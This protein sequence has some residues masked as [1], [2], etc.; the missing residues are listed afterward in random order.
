LLKSIGE[1]CRRQCTVVHFPGR[2]RMPAGIQAEAVSGGSGDPST[3]RG[4]LGGGGAL[5]VFG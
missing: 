2:N 5:D 1:L 3:D 4:A